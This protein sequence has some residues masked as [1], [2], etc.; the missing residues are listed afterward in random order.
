MEATASRRGPMW[1][2]LSAAVVAWTLFGVFALWLP[3]LI[4]RARTHDPATRHHATAAVN[5]GLTSLIVLVT[6]A[7]LSVL[8]DLDETSGSSSGTQP[9][10]MMLAACYVLVGMVALVV[11]AARTAFG[12][13]FR[14][15][16]A[17]SLRLVR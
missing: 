16:G 15:I 11:G 2:Y 9:L 14:F 13:E 5:F 12:K 10:P 8:L 7:L 6:G 17:M 3:P 1:S 4:I